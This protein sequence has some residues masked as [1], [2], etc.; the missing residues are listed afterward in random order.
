MWRKK[1]LIVEDNLELQEICS[2]H[3]ESAWFEVQVSSDWLQGV[4][5][6]VDN[7]PDIVILD[8]MMPGMDGFEVLEVIRDHSS[9]RIP[10]IVYSNLSSEDDEKRALELGASL[11]LRKSDYEGDIVVAKAVDLL[12]EKK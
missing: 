7:P 2:I 6:L 8:I 4:T 9:F 12:Q 10:V 11:Y 5:W 1:V 3:F